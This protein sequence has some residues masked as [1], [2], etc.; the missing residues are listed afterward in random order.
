MQKDIVN[1][2]Q[3][4]KGKL[5]EYVRKLADSKVV[6]LDKKTIALTKLKCY[7]PMDLYNCIQ[8]CLMYALRQSMPPRQNKNIDW[9]GTELICNLNDKWVLNI[10]DELEFGKSWGGMEEVLK[11]IVAQKFPLSQVRMEA[12]QKLQNM[13]QVF[14]SHFKID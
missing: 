11:E 2:E 9:L 4:V 14:N 6:K 7:K 10:T 1:Y 3:N 5:A 13:G 8:L 12:F